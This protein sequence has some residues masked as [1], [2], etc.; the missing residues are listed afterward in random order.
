[1]SDDVPSRRPGGRTAR[2]R[3]DVLAALD[4]LLTEQ[5]YDALSIE[6]VA[7]RS[8]VHRTTIYRR[9]GSVAMLL[10]DLLHLGTEDDWRPPDTGS[11]AGDLTA[12]NR[13]LYEALMVE[14]SLTTAVIAA[15]FRT[16]EAAEALSRF[17]ADRYRRSEVVV[18][19]AIERGDIRAGTDAQQLLVSATGPLFHQ[20]VLLRRP[21]TRADADAYAHAA[22]AGVAGP[23]GDDAASHLR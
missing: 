5:G 23:G 19:R 7:D 8:G 2:I 6:D 14:P 9:W 22:L 1:M 13:E 18:R 21:I 20:R 10:V 3:A 12:I 17:W 4:A 15:S 11:L 16:P